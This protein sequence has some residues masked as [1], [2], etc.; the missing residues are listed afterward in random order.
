ALR[1]LG[2]PGCGR[3]L[4][5]AVAA[6]PRVPFGRRPADAGGEALVLILPLSRPAHALAEG[7]LEP[8][9]L[10]PAGPTASHAAL[11][12]DLGRAF[13][14]AKDHLASLGSLALPCPGADLLGATGEHAAAGLAALAGT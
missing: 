5:T 8:A 6:W 2:R 1:A 3:A 14:T 10:L 4:A 13:A 7:I 9:P 12:I 11:G